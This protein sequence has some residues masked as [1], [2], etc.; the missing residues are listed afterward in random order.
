MAQSGTL[1]LH[2]R[3]K[4]VAELLAQGATNNE[5]AKELGTT[6]KT[7]S[8]QVYAIFKR[9][10]LRSRHELT[11]VLAY[12]LYTP[13]K[14]TVELKLLTPAQNRVARLYASGMRQ[15]EVAKELGI[16]GKT[17]S[18]HLCAVFEKLGVWNASELTSLLVRVQLGV[19][20]QPKNF[21]KRPLTSY[22][23]GVRPDE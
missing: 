7:V 5:I 15:A 21:V 6:P 11:F 20:P 8:S 9:N 13:R 4:Q 12:Q 17:V 18:A 2:P 3:E 22:Q 1:I 10:H 19:T 23:A 14:L 16:S